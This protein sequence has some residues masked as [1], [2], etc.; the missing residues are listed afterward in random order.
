[1]RPL[2]TCPATR[3]TASVNWRSTPS[4][5]YIERGGAFFAFHRK[6]R[7]LDDLGTYLS[8]GRRSGFLSACAGA[9]GIEVRTCRRT[10]LAIRPVRQRIR[11]ARERQTRK[12]SQGGRIRL[13]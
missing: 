2:P 9:D 13:Q 11:E 8:V 12:Q 1:M 6:R 7:K 3:K 10:G 4:D 5:R